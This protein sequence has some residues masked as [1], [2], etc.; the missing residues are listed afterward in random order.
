MNEFDL[1]ITRSNAGAYNILILFC[2]SI[3]WV[4]TNM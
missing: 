1:F 3:R 4:L 2:W